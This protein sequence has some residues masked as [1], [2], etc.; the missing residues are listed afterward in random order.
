M[1]VEPRR[2][3]HHDRPAVQRAVGEGRTLAAAMPRL[4]LEARRV[5]AT[6]HPRPARPP[7]RRIRGEFLAVPPLRLRRAGFPRRLAALGAR[8]SS[9][10]A[11]AGMGGR[12]YGLDL[13]RS[14][15]VDGVRLAAGAR[16]QAVPRAGRGAGA[17]RSSGRRR[18][19]RRDSRPHAPDRQPQRHRAHGAGDR[20]RSQRAH[21]P[22]AELFR[23]PRSPRS[24]SSRICGARSAT[25]GAR[26][27][28]L[29][30][31]AR[32]VT[33]CRSSI[34]PRRLSPIGA[35]SNSSSRKAAAASPP[36]V[37]KPGGPIM[38]RACARHRA[39]IRSE[40]DRLGW[41][42]TIHRTDR[43]ASELLLALHARIGAA[44]P[45]A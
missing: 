19:A 27:R 45:T 37:P 21:E 40:T 43:P 24:C 14:F 33:S 28:S 11:R 35:A 2:T 29:P 13:A 36:A 12:A 7:P 42:F 23:P 25:C 31:A 41:S 8:R 4:I 30:A 9:L 26:S 39:E 10:C 38:R 18:R 20:A 32:A 44:W 22:A 15:A 34:P 1:A 16:H 6:V 3:S 5:A 17:R